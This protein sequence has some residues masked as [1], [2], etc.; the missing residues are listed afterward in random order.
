[1]RIDDV[2]WHELLDRQVG[3]AS[4]AQALACGWNRRAV[5]H[6]LGTTWQRLLPGVY[7]TVTGL[8]TA[9]QKAWAGVL[10]AGPE[11][12]DEARAAGTAPALTSWS[13]LAAWGLET[14]PTDVHVALPHARRLH[15]PAFLVGEGKVVLH[16]TTRS[17]ESRRTLPTLRVERCVIDACLGVPS[18]D[19]VRAVVSTAVQRGRTTVERLL[20]ELEK[21]PQRGSGHLRLVLSEVGEGARSAP[22]AVLVR[23]L[24]SAELPAYRLNGDVHDEDGRWLARGDVVI[25]EVKVLVEVDGQRWHLRGD[26]WVADVERHT[27]LE[28]AGWTVLR[29]PASRVLSDPAGVVAEIMRVVVRLQGRAV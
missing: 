14:E 20:V 27:R 3:V 8:P 23:A 28:V 22:E 17:L 26:R 18:L 7:L 16:R 25:D 10:L 6:R 11:Q 19:S 1:M 9:E 5:E 12:D 21:A 29:Y 15:A 13:G 24:R 4:R 2:A